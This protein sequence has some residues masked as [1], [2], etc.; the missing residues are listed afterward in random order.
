MNTVANVALDESEFGISPLLRLSAPLH[1]PTTPGIIEPTRLPK[2]SF[3]FS[4]IFS[5]D[6]VAMQLLQV[7]VLYQRLPLSHSGHAR[8]PLQDP[9][10]VS[11][12]PSLNCD[13]AGRFHLLA[14]PPAY[15]MDRGDQGLSEPR[16]YIFDLQALQTY[17]SIVDD[18]YTERR[19]QYDYSLLLLPPI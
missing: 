9:N 2:L 15:R 13:T 7:V 8:G 18:L 12:F 1:A 10:N 16:K 11:T 6:G 14:K 5:R 3:S 17:S 19:R 4:M